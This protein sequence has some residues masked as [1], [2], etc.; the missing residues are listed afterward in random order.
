MAS[1]PFHF[2][3]RQ[4]LTY[5]TGQVAWD[6]PRLVEGIKNASSATIYYHTHHFMER[7][8]FLSPE[9]PNDFAHW[10]ANAL[11]DEVLGEQIAAIDLRE[12]FALRAIRLK[13][14]EV[15]EHAMEHNTE[16]MHRRAPAG[17]EFH[18]MKAQT[19][20]FPTKYV[21]HNLREFKK[22]LRKVSIA[23]IYY[24]MFESRLR[25]QQDTSDFSLWLKDS[26]GQQELAARFM[27]LD[28][29]TQSLENLR[30]HLI[31]LIDK[32]IS[33]RKRG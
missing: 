13:I 8:D 6:L 20:V 19:F 21:A 27:K 1:E 7:H 24:H 25:L 11:Q 33:V 2:Y 26:L 18:F 16:A 32:K 12:Y 23:S 29:Y 30:S 31:K 22:C 4:N 9:P 15:I 10:I 28:P 5:L 14:I 3:T 17:E